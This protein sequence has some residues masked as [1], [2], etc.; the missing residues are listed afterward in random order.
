VALGNGT[1]TPKKQHANTSSS[2]DIE[3]DWHSITENNIEIH[4][5]IEAGENLYNKAFPSAVQGGLFDTLKGRIQSLDK[6][7]SKIFK[8]YKETWHISK[9]M[10]VCIHKLL[11]QH[12]KDNKSNLLSVAKKFYKK[13]TND[14]KSHRL[15]LAYYLNSFIKSTNELILTN[16]VTEEDIQTLKDPFKDKEFAKEYSNSLDMLLLNWVKSPAIKKVEDDYIIE[17]AKKLNGLPIPKPFTTTQRPTRPA[18]LPPTKGE[19]T[20]LPGKLANEALLKQKVQGQTAR[21]ESPVLKA[22]ANGAF[23]KDNT[24][25]LAPKPIVPFSLDQVLKVT[26]KKVEQPAEKKKVVNGGIPGALLNGFN[27]KWNANIA[28]Q[29][30]V[31]EDEGNDGEWGNE[32]LQTFTPEKPRAVVKHAFVPNPETVGKA[33]SPV[34]KV[35]RIHKEIA[36]LKAKLATPGKKTAG[37]LEL[38]NTM[39]STLETELE[40]NKGA[41]ESGT[42]MKLANQNK[43]TRI[44]KILNGDDTWSWGYFDDFTAVVSLDK[45]K[46]S[47]PQDKMS[48]EKLQ[49]VIEEY[50]Q[51]QAA[52]EKLAKD[53]NLE[54]DDE[55]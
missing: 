1:F 26:L 17:R 15:V 14:E 30:N 34:E 37:A 52:Y 35:A 12:R 55:W 43:K 39:I 40:L 27:S 8:E 51:L 5:L 24:G 19:K 42:A 44:Q 18:P 29:E 33:E 47:F 4:R 22:N 54:L 32:P 20:E 2:D 11:W 13:I 36:D 46:K 48:T 25:N 6:E 21:M 31:V 53:F 23:L 9:I 7:L 16:D 3:G 49:K 41:T 50:P 28:H 10:S 38:L 45:L